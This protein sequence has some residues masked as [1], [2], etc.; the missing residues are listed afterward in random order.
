MYFFAVLV[1]LGTEL[2][3]VSSVKS[4]VTCTETTMTVAIERASYPGLLVGHLQLLKPADTRCSFQSNS[5]HIYAVVPLSNCGTE[6]QEDE[7]NL[8]F[9]NEITSVDNTN[10]VI[11]RKCEVKVQFQC[12]YPKRGK[13][14]QTFSAHRENVTVLEKGFG[15]FTYEFEFYPDSQYRNVISARSYPLECQLRSRMFMQIKA[16]TTLSNTEL[17]VE[18]CSAA[19]YDNPNSMPT[20]PIIDR[21]CDKDSTV[22]RHPSP[23]K[24]HFRFSME[25]FKFIGLHDQVYISCSVMM[26][27]MEADNTRCSQ[28][29]INS[30]RLGRHVRSEAVTQTS[31][32]L[33][34]QGPLRLKRSAE[35]AESPVMNPN[36][37]LNL[38]FIA[39]CLLAAVG[40]IC[41]V[42]MYKTKVSE[43]KYQPLN[44][45]ESVPAA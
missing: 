12:Q 23:T 25:A 5:T 40:M 34:S 2:R 17:F 8:I 22:K 18:S 13:V 33:V 31:R 3:T 1:L 15:R 14:K 36:L 35:G 27:E 4:S 6:I 38:V 39:G 37:N 41:A 9:K 29:C 43:V 32:H 20:Y 16:T 19:P 42:V 28:G 30:G 44:A 10:E 24:R 45:F 21:G 11:T 7:N 26:C